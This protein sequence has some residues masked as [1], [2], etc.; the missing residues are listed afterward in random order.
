MSAAHAGPE[1]SLGSVIAAPPSP[2]S[3][4]TRRVVSLRDVRAERAA[5]TL[6]AVQGSVAHA[7][8]LVESAHARVDLTHG[9]AKQYRS[10]VRRAIADGLVR[11]TRGDV[12]RWLRDLVAERGC[13]PSTA[14]FYLRAMK[15]ITGYAEHLA[16][17]SLELR[18][19][20]SAFALVRQLKTPTR[21]SR[22]PPRDA[23]WRALEVCRDPAE[24]A[25]VWLCTSGL[26]KHEVLG[27]MPE[28]YNRR[29]RQ[30]D[31][32]R[33]R[34]DVHDRACGRTDRQRKNGEH[35]YVD[36]GDDA[37]R[38]LEWTLANYGA[39]KSKTGWHRAGVLEGR[40]FPWGERR[41]ANFMQ[42]IRAAVPGFDAGTAWHG[43]RHLGATTVAELTN[44]NVQAV[45]AFLGDRSPTVA[46]MYCEPVRGHTRADAAALAAA[47]A[48]AK[49]QAELLRGG[50]AAPLIDG[51]A[52]DLKPEGRASVST[53]VDAHAATP[54]QSAPA[55]AG[56]TE[57]NRTSARVAHAYYCESAP[58]EPVLSED[59]PLKNGE[60]I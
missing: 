47:L 2:A 57:S 46:G 5:D 32:W 44:G 34:P 28:D 36:L 31:V 25:F 19:L 18:Q 38:E 27:L 13:S 11:P 51:T 4:P 43:F 55:K 8:A 7:W 49:R 45:Q 48:M 17:E 12:E 41:V 60:S 33:Q 9:T 39:V 40:I 58:V 22:C 23:L 21:A 3:H 16:P 10:A 26:R 56:S 50:S 14:N 53:R 29:T 42:R 59:K 37:A 30:L 52:E 20:A 35:H 24:R 1:E 6:R 15:A 54:N